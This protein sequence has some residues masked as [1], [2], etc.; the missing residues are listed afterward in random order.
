M[1]LGSHATG[2]RPVILHDDS[3]VSRR[4]DRARAKMKDDDE[5]GVGVDRILRAYD[6]S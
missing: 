2:V 5:I 6:G 1:Q 3:T 4:Y